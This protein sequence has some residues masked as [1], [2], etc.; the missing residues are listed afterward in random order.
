[1]IPLIFFPLGPVLERGEFLFFLYQEALN[2]V[3]LFCVGFGLKQLLEVLDVR[4]GDF[5][6]HPNL[7]VA[8]RASNSR[9]DLPASEPLHKGRYARRALHSPLETDA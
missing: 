4:P 6:R 9:L 7:P 1:M 5:C 8:S 2:D 3:A